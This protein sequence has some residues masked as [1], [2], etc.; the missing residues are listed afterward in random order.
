MTELVIDSTFETL[1]K[2]NYA[3]IDDP[4]ILGLAQ[5][6]YKAS[7]DLQDRQK[8]EKIDPNEIKFY[9]LAVQEF[10]KIYSASAVTNGSLEESLR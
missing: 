10:H 8:S 1:H 7:K 6:L 2:R 3:G 5:N 4:I 9:H